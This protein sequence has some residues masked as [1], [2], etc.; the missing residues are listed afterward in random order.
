MMTNNSIRFDFAQIQEI[1]RLTRK[2]ELFIT[3]CELRLKDKKYNN[4]VISFGLSRVR[5]LKNLN[6]AL[7]KKVA[8]AHAVYHLMSRFGKSEV[9]DQ[10]DKLLIDN[11]ESRKDFFKNDS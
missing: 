11:H 6:R 7:G 5:G 9:L 1:Y 8:F 2:G 10:T 4:E 3:S